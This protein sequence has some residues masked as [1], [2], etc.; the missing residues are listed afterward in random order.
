MGSAVPAIRERRSPKRRVGV[1]TSYRSGLPRK[2]RSARSL[3]HSG[4]PRRRGRRLALFLALLFAFG[5]GYSIVGLAEERTAS[6]VG[7]YTPTANQSK[8][9]TWKVASSATTCENLGVLVDRSHSLP[10][11]YVPEDLVPLRDY[12]VSTL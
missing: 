2:G 9:K 11:D 7:A 4:V 1:P 5:V 3:R 12:G 6:A 8:D 10:S